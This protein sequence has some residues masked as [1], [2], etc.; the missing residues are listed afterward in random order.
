MHEFLNQFEGNFHI[1]NIT[2]PNWYICLLNYVSLTLS[3]YYF[4]VFIV[5]I[6][7]L[8]FWEGIVLILL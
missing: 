5:E 4:V 3:Q 2:F 8:N 6:L 7:A 1:N